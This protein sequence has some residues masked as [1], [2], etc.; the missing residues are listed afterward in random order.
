LRHVFIT[1]RAKMTQLYRPR[2]HK[3]K[4]PAEKFR[5]ENFS[6]KDNPAPMSHRGGENFTETILGNIKSVGI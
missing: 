1:N 6:R 2:W 3:S 4:F 5:T